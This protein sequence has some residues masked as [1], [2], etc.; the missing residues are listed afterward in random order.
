MPPVGPGRLRLGPAGRLNGGHVGLLSS[1]RPR[2]VPRARPR[3]R[4]GAG[5]FLAA[6]G[7]RFQAPAAA[8]EPKRVEGLR[9]RLVGCG[10][11]VTWVHVLRASWS[12]F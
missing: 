10:L 9:G 1:V 12:G 11:T 4:P 7:E 3:A 6:F 2:C 5:P 8:P